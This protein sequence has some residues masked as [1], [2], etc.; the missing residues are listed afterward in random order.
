M[1]LTRK[2]AGNLVMRI[3]GAFLETPALQL[4]IPQAERRFGLHS[5]VCEPVLRLLADAGVLTVTP[6]GA[7]KRLYPR[8]S[9]AQACSTRAA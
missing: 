1:K 5:A 9:R 4:T 2:Q 7:F 3:Q 8:P 6:Q